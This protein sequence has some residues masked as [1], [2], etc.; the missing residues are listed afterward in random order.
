VNFEGPTPRPL[1]RF[2]LFVDPVDGKVVVDKTVKCQVQLSTCD[3]ADFF[4]A[5]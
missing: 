5:T 2:K 4:I 1:E 3:A